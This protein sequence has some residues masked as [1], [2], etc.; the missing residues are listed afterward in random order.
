MLLLITGIS[1]LLQSFNSTSVFQSGKNDWWL[2]K[3][4][5][6]VR[7]T[8]KNDK[9]AISL[10]FW[11]S[12]IYLSLAIMESVQ[13]SLV[14]SSNISELWLNYKRHMCENPK[15]FIQPEPE[16]PAL[17]SSH[18]SLIWLFILTKMAWNGTYIFKICMLPGFQNGKAQ[19]FILEN[20]WDSHFTLWD[21]HH[22]YYTMRN[23]F[24]LEHYQV[25]YF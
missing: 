4:R 11:F 19:L 13:F 24:W 22:F 9:F 10:P 20:G 12:L 6:F 25:S 1:Q 7:N 23:N 8:L 3:T 15:V 5:S 16:F 14:Y 18:T 2:S 21:F 17:T